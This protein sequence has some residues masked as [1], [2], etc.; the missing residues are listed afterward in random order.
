[1]KTKLED[2]ELNKRLAGIRILSCD[3][4]GVLTDG[5]LYYDANGQLLL[6]FNVQDGMG[7]KL[8]MNA[9]V[10]VCLI[11]Q[12][13]NQIIPQRAKALGIKY[14]FT[15]VEDKSTRIIELAGELGVDMSEVC[16]IADDVND[17]SLLTRVGVP[18]TVANGVKQVKDICLLTTTRAGGHGAV[19]ELCDQILTL[20]ETLERGD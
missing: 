2:T 19:R 17:L 14:C 6:R 18:V 15:G 11:S 9:G 4:D 20:R 10:T 16:H 8:L 12:S 7:L 13:R 5:G 1:M 3:V